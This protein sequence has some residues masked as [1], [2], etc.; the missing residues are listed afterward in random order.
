LRDHARFGKA[1]RL[2]EQQARFARLDAV[3]GERA[4]DL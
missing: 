3:G 4:V 2:G 1:A